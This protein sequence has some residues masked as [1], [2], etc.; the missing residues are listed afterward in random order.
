[1]FSSDYYLGLTQTGL[2]SQSTPW[3]G[4]ALSSLNGRFSSMADSQK[5]CYRN[6][7]EDLSIVRRPCQ[8]LDHHHSPQHTVAVTIDNVVYTCLYT[9][10][11]MGV[12]H[13]WFHM[14]F[15]KMDVFFYC[16]A[17][18]LCH[19]FNDLFSDEGCQATF[20]SSFMLDLT[21]SVQQLL[22]NLFL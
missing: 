11:S 13:L 21:T 2:S 8:P 3:P 5:C 18:N 17:K 9:T 15:Q 22:V 12:T 6:L 7:T 4:P 14:V 19:L 20:G 10:I 1:M 16:S